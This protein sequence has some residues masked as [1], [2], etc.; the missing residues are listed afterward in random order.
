MGETLPSWFWVLYYCFFLVTIA[1]AIW[2]MRQKRLVNVACA[3]L[4]LSIMIPIAHM[5]YNNGK[6]EGLNELAYFMQNVD[7]GDLWAIYLLAL[8]CYIVVWWGMVAVKG[9]KV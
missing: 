2:C 9:K 3:A 8:Y 6:V 7:Q 4:I 1:T 5:F